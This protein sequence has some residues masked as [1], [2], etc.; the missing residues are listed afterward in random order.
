MIYTILSLLSNAKVD[1]PSNY[2]SQFQVNDSGASLLDSILNT[3]YFFAGA[4]AVIAI[5]V[6][7]FWYITGGDNPSQVQKGKNAIIYAS[8]GLV[9]VLAAFGITGFVSGSFV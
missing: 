6:G 4:A 2:P 5:I 3:V 7:A 1:L 9:I 8:I